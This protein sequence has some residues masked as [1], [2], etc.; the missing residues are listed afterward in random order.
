MLD[1]FKH[2]TTFVF[3]VDGV[4]TDGTL[5]VLPDGLMAR[6]MNI[7]DGFAL[8]EAVNAGYKIVIISGGNSDSVRNRLSNLGIENIFLGVENK[9][10]ILDEVIQAN[11]L[12]K[13][14]ILYMGDDLPDFE[15]MCNSGVPCCPADAVPEIKEISIYVS[16]VNGGEGCVRDVIEQVMR[17]HGKWPLLKM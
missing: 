7:K 15:V 2:I 12:S 1:K 6:R 9:K 5:F 11:K 16:P 17:V 3:D 14:N 13:K 8:K 10:K 4:L